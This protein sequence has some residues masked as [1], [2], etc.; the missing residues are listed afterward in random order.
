MKPQQP[1]NVALEHAVT[2]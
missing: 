1:T 2:A